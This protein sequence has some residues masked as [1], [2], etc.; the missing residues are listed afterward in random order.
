MMAVIGFSAIF[1]GDIPSGQPRITYFG[2]LR[3]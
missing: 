2:N 3:D 1:I